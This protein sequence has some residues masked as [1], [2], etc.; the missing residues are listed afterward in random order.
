MPHPFDPE[1][2]IVLARAFDR[3][4]ATYYRPGRLTISQDSARLTLA[5]HLVQMAKDGVSEEDV[6]A[7]GGLS[8]LNSLTSEDSA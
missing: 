3:V 1:L 2:K 7:E 4:W 6:L 8:Y 5:K